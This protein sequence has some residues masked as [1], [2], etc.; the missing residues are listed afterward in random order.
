MVLRHSCDNPPCVN[1]DHLVPGTC[2]DNSR[3]M[4]ERRRHWRH[5]R[6]ECDK[7][8]DLTLPGAIKHGKSAD[9]CAECDRERRRESEDRRR[10]ALGVPSR[11]ILAPDQVAEIRRRRAGGASLKELGADF[12]LSIQAISDI[13]TGRSY[14]AAA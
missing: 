2:A 7:G 9:R 10:R 12:G 6:A 5:D 14:P 4:V 8:H 3:D 13:C 11:R 1:P